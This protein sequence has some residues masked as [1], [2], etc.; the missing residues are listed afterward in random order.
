[1]KT[2]F[3]Y[4]LSNSQTKFLDGARVYPFPDADT[5]I[6]IYVNRHNSNECKNGIAKP[7]ATVNINFPTI[8]SCSADAIELFAAGLV[9]AANLA[10][11]IEKK[12]AA[13]GYLILGDD[14]SED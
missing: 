2:E 13:G 12:I 9:E 7:D 8:G 4:G 14:W 1:M 5:D 6:N 11:I 3:T 10:R